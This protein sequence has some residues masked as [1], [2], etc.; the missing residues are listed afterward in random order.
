MNNENEQVF[1]CKIGYYFYFIKL[2]LTQRLINIEIT[3]NS[4]INNQNTKYINNYRLSHFQ[5]INPYFKLFQSI[6]DVYKNIITLLKKKKFFII[7]N[8]D[9]TLSFILKIKIHDKN[10]KI[11]LSLIKSQNKGILKLP[12]ANNENY[13][14]NLN[15]ELLNLKNKINALEQN[16]YL[17][18]Y[19]NNYIPTNQFSNISNNEYNQLETII[20]KMN[21]L[22]NE[23]NAKNK[24]IKML[25]KEINKYEEN[26]VYINEDEEEN[27]E[28]DD[29]INE[30]DDEKFNMNLS[31]NSSNN[32]NNKGKINHHNSFQKLYS[33]NT[34]F[35]HHKNKKGNSMDKN[36]YPRDNTINSK[37]NK[38][39]TI[40][41]RNNKINNEINPNLSMDQ[42]NN[43]YNK[44]QTFIPNSK[45]YKYLNSIPT[46]KKEKILNLNSKIIFTNKEYK[47]ILQRISE[48]DKEMKVELNLLYRASSDGDFEEAFRNN[49]ENKL[50]TLTLF[51]T[52]E[53]ARFGFYIEK[54]KKTTI[55]SGTKI[56][57]V[58]GTSFIIGLNNLIYYNVFMKKNSLYYKSDNLLCFGY[59]SNVNNNK[60]RW[61]VYT[62]R[63]N[64]IGKKYLFGDKNDVYLNLDTNKI[65]GNNLS[66]HIKDVEVFEVDIKYMY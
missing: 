44:V 40:Y 18:S 64:F 55:K 3:S 37:F 49:V 4:A 50:K 32:I 1:R 7:Q 62:K 33:I 21:Q 53:G 66:Y 30:N 20:S 11:K 22:E 13:I 39:K 34:D 57:E 51:H 54:R 36:Y 63:N 25:E 61:L 24:R 46:I 6:K 60:T 48:G 23:N 10:S 27:E 5:E 38:I 52:E 26:K 58:P 29:N 45:A 2:L 31:K 8:E 17:L 43:N 14:S 42:V 19:P 41:E 28:I 15:N 59:C 9:N 12:K 47:L 35:V 16:Q 65:I 56:L